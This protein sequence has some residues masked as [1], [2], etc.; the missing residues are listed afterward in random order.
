MSVAGVYAAAPVVIF[1][2]PY[3]RCLDCDQWVD[4]YVDLPEGSG[5]A[6]LVPCGHSS[7]RDVCVSWSPVDGCDCEGFNARHPEA[8][9]AHGQRAR[10]PGDVRAL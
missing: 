5:A 7:Y 3:K 8:L 9:S 1:A 4:G 6:V 10:C 2:D